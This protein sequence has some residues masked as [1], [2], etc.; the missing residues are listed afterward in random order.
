M[1]KHSIV[2]AVLCLA[3]TSLASA[4]FTAYNDFVTDY[5]TAANVTN[6]GYSASGPQALKDQAT[7]IAVTPTMTLTYYHMS[8]N[9][10]GPP[11]EIAGGTDA[12]TIFGGIVSTKNKVDAYNS[13][14]L[15]DWYVT[16]GFNDLNP[17]KTY[18]LAAVIDRGK[19]D[20]ANDRWTL[21]SLVDAGPSTYACSSG[22][23]QVSAT[24]VSID[25]YNTVNGYVAQWT[26]IQPGAGGAF[27]LRFAP[28]I[29]AELPEAYRESNQDG[30]GYAPAGIMLQEVPEPASMALL[31]LGGLAL[32]KRRKK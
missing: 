3:L 13:G 31:A 30:R 14:Y 10:T 6:W 27:T 2:I 23:Y 24:A 18:N 19:A 4:D 32:L 5:T 21:I 12:A 1:K 29:D 17:A 16:L 11:G 15:G 20:Y 9:T 28:A 25:N 7:G 22:A 26:G 8:N